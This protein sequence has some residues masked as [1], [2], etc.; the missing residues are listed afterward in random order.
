MGA[1]F[2]NYHIR[3]TDAK[4]CARALTTL[5]SSRALITDSKNGWITVYDE[6]SDSQDIEVLRR[7]AKGLSSKLKTA[8]IA[9]MVHDGDVFMY[10]LF[11][12]GEVVDQ[13]DS[14]PDYFGPVSDAKRKEWAGNFSRL[15]R[16]T[17][18]GT[19]LGD[20]K[21][22]SDMKLR[23]D[24]DERASEFAKLLGID[25]ARSRTGFK[26]VQETKHR[27][28]LV[29]AKGHSR[30]QAQLV[31]A[32][33]RGDAAKVKELLEKGTSPHQKD[34]FGQP[35][36]V[37]AGRRGKL[38]MVRDLTAHG[39]DLFSECPGGGDA[40]W[41]A[42]AEGHEQIVAHL[43]EK[44][45]GNPK[46]PSS[47]RT[48]F[49]A[50]VMAGRA[51]VLKELVLAGA[52]VTGKNTFGQLPLLLASM[53]GN[54]FIWEAHAKKPF[55]HRPGDRPANWKEVV[56]ILLE[57]GAQIPFPVKEGT[58][59]VKSLSADQKSKLADALLEVGKKIKLPDN[60][61]GFGR[62][63]AACTPKPTRDKENSED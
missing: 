50:A 46:L 59:D 63:D 40:L 61:L 20:L 6:Q 5:I 48:A 19:S 35:L 38:D 1:S 30:D 2:S 32:V 60:V 25:P 42:A 57:A 10:L 21:R 12:N 28:E 24:E 49:S 56:L 52:D 33:S 39:A 45:K 17:K 44:A 15:L 13:F 41:I 7:L 11:D 9:M 14:K 37:V 36:L 62:Q 8:V 58:I 31:E 16:Y 29:Y 18:K 47:L 43:L 27:F 51:D 26:Y 4:N 55:P 23:F 22:A 3:K 53:R 34:R 54:E